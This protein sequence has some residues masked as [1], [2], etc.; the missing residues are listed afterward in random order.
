M[1][2][3]SL[4]VLA[5]QCLLIRLSSLTTFVEVALGLPT[6]R[7]VGQ[8]WLLPPAWNN[9]LTRKS[10]KSQCIYFP[11]HEDNRIQLLSTVRSR[12]WK[13]NF[14]GILEGTSTHQV[15][16]GH[17]IRTVD[18]RHMAVYTVPRCEASQSGCCHRINFLLLVVGLWW[19]ACI[20]LICP[21]KPTQSNFPSFLPVHLPFSISVFSVQSQGVCL[22]CLA[23]PYRISLFSL[24]LSN[25]KILAIKKIVHKQFVS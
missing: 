8:P 25:L 10:L 21:S 7:E 17:L 2:Q 5:G 15:A 16:V 3:W 14:Y 23:I 12:R 22:F 6:K 4:L 24:S 20:F 13:N 9:F 19:S 11:P 18:V 1:W